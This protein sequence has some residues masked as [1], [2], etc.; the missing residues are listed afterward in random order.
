MVLY[1]C[2]ICLYLCRLFNLIPISIKMNGGSN[3]FLVEGLYSM[4]LITKMYDSSL[5]DQSYCTAA[6]TM[7]NFIFA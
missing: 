1:H 4:F 5:Y 6:S 7:Q 2:F 3:V